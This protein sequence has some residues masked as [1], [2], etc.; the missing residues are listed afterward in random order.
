METGI[1]ENWFSRLEKAMDVLDVKQ[2]VISSNVANVNTPAFQRREV[3]F[4]SEMEKLLGTENSSEV[5]V[6]TTN[7]NMLQAES[8]AEATMP[9][10]DNRSPARNDGNN[11]SLEKEMVD[12]AETGE[13]YA[14]LSRI[15]SKN[16]KMTRYVISG[17][18]N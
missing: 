15:A 4:K 7:P 18:R 8:P 12:L 5:S 9:I 3:D 1:V 13:V 10:V 11:V 17:G 14:A 2:R 16:L 6:Q